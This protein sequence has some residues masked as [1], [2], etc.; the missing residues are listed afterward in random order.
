MDICNLASPRSSQQSL[1][2]K[3]ITPS[4]TDTTN[5]KTQGENLLVK[6]RERIP[7]TEGSSKLCSAYGTVD[8]S[9]LLNLS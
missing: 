3:H 7:K 5:G 6:H 4:C 2:P 8:L 1:L 9:Q